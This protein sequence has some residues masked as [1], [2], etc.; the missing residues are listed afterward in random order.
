MFLTSRV[1]LKVCSSIEYIMIAR[2][3]ENIY[4]NH[5]LPLN[6]HSVG[7]KDAESSF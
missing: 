2:D 4:H 7:I 5:S 6:K 3:I 1:S